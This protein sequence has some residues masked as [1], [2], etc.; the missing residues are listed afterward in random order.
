MKKIIKLSK[1]ENKILNEIKDSKIKI[2]KDNNISQTRNEILQDL[3]ILKS[4][5]SY[6]NAAG[7]EILK[8]LHKNSNSTS[9]N[10]SENADNSQYEEEEE[11]NQE[12]SNASRDN[13]EE[14]EF[15]GKYTNLKAIK[16]NDIVI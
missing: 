16:T 4:E 15:K 11:V 13:E 14:E 10:N 8:S 6:T 2:I 5:E 9:L 7:H 3:N 1:E 12:D